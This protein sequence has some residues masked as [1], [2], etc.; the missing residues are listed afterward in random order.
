PV[1]GGKKR[2]LDTLK[3]G[4]ALD[5]PCVGERMA[6]DLLWIACPVT[7]EELW[8][9]RDTGRDLARLAITM[10]CRAVAVLVGKHLARKPCLDE[11]VAM[12]AAVVAPVAVVVAPAFPGNDGGE[13]RWLQGGDKPLCD[14]VVGN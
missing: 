7:F 11:G 6:R 10:V 14:C 4:A 13:V 5:V 1:A 2:H 8:I 9:E 3:A 12:N